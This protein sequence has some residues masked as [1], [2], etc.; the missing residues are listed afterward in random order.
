MPFGRPPY[1]T[2]P[3]PR[4]DALAPTSGTARSIRATAVQAAAATEV[5]LLRL[6]AVR[7]TRPSL[8][9]Y[10]AL[11]ARG[12]ETAAKLVGGAG[13]YERPHH[14]AI[15]NPLR[16]KIGAFNHGGPAAELARKF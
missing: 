9:L 4:L 11:T 2:R 1:E 8:T 16:T 13:R 10:D 6:A 7:Q 5:R 15:I 3:S 14:G 12:L